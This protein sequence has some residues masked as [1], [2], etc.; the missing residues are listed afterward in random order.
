MIRGLVS[1]IIPVY[2]RLPLLREAVGSVLAQTYARF[3]LILVDD[4]SD[5]ETAAYCDDLARTYP[6]ITALHLT[7]GGHA[8]RAR[9]AGR[10]LARGEFIQYLDSDDLLLPRK[11]ELMVKALNDNPECDIAYCFTRRYARG[12][13]P[14]DVACE[15]TGDTFAEM[16]PEC[17]R[18]R[19]WHTSTPLYTRRICDKAGPWSSLRFWEDV[20]YDLRMANAGAKLVHCREFLTDFRDHTEDRLSKMDFFDDPACMRHAPDAYRAM[21]LQV[22]SSRV[23]PEHPAVQAFMAELKWVG[24]KCHAIGLDREAE[25]LRDMAAPGIALH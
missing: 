14:V 20:E 2:N 8:G 17:L 16:L 6:E 25:Q 24:E 7:H 21:L 9:E 18:G 3:E 4:G 1:T 15:R 12:D 22:R 11:F 19:F 23:S 5:D 10:K 13:S